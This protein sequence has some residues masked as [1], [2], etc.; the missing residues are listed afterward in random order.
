MDCGGRMIKIAIVDDEKTVCDDLKTMLRQYERKNMLNFEIAIYNS[1]E[2][3]L[4]DIDDGQ[5]FDLLLLDIELAEING[6]QVGCHIRNI[7]RDY[8]CQIIYISAKTG[9]ALEL[10][11][12]RP[13]HFLI[14]PITADILFPCLNDYVERYLNEDYFEFIVKNVRKRIPVRRIMYFESNARKIILHCVEEKYEFY[15]KLSDLTEMN[16]L[17]Q[18]M[19]IHKSF[20]V[21]ISHVSSY[22]YATLVVSNNMEL[23]ISKP[24]R[25][26]VRRL[27]LKYSAEKYK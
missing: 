8:M 23:P 3:L 20:Y 19:M 27:F 10:F 9:Y 12:I 18:F 26:E 2:N 7:N 1:G 14:K 11:Q 24:N 21:N 25:K 5:S 13:F 6:V 15:G 4:A 17:K 16:V 22:K